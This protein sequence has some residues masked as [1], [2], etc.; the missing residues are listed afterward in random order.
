MREKHYQEKLSAF[1][2]HELPSDERQS[3]GEHLLHCAVCRKEHDEIKFGVNLAKNL[4]RTN[5]PQSVWSRIEAELNSKSLPQIEAV[6]FFDFRKAAFT[7]I[8]LIAVFGLSTIV[9]LNVW[10]TNEVVVNEQNDSQQITQT[11]NSSAWQVET[12]AGSPKIKN[13][14]KQTNLAVGGFVE[15]DERSRVKIDVADIGQVEVAPNSLVKLVNSSEKEHRLSLERGTLNARIFAPPR[16]FVVDTPTAV[17]VDLGCAYKL[18]VDDDGNSKLH[19][20]SGYVALESEGRE[21]IVPANAFCFTKRGKGLGTPYFETASA[22][23]Q[24]AL[25]EFDFE[26]GGNSALQRVLK[27]SK[28]KD[29]LTLWHLL[30]RVSTDERKEVLAKI[31]SFVKLPEDVTKEGILRLDKNMLEKLKDELEISWYKVR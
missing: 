30:S 17:A 27:L 29:T 16:L 10:R 31:N 21:S 2:N 20:T 18:E 1:I 11:E 8:L 25:Q 6:S 14:S 3:V 4:K 26:D 23:F 9:Y 5:A 7:S 22:E 19:V 13:S 28:L 15:T 24:E 12:L